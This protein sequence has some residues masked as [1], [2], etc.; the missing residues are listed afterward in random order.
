MLPEWAIRQSTTERGKLQP[1]L[2]LGRSISINRKPNALLKLGGLSMIA[3]GNP[4]HAKRYHANERHCHAKH[5]SNGNQVTTQNNAGNQEQRA[6]SCRSRNL[7]VPATAIKNDKS[8]GYWNDCINQQFHP[9]DLE[10]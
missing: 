4:I 2:G 8:H 3:A 5:G 10:P 9:P 7:P 6:R 1:V